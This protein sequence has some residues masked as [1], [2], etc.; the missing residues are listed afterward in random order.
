MVLFGGNNAL[1]K[2]DIKCT[3]LYERKDTFLHSEWV[4]IPGMS[5]VD[6]LF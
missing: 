1:L 2:V 5:N 4:W 6:V 3:T